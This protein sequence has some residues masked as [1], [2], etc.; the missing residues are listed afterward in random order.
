MNRSIFRL[1]RFAFITAG[2]FLIAMSII[3]G[4][5]YFVLAKMTFPGDRIVYGSKLS[6]TAMNLRNE[7][8]KH[9]EVSHIR[10]QSLDGLVLDGLHIKRQNPKACAVMCHGYRSAKEFMYRFMDIFPEWDILLFDFRAH[11]KSEGSITSIGFH[12]YK[13]VIAAAEYIKSHSPSGIP[14]YILG[15]SM[16][17]AASL[18]AAEIKEDLCDALIIDSTYARL[19]SLVIKSFSS[20]AHLPLYPFFPVIKILFGRMAAFDMGTM[21]PEESA[22]KIKVPILFMHSIK[23]TFISPSNALKLYSRVQNKRSKLWIAP[24]CRHGWLHTYYPKLYRKKVLKFL[25]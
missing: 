20:K 21:N 22:A 15:I 8:L 2:I 6:E 11:G 14:C 25:A 24:D 19:T 17:G 12:E 13:D 5:S 4:I 10:F 1:K 23:D 3:V 9:P 7:L 18:R 16:G